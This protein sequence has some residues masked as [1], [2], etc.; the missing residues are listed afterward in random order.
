MFEDLTEEQIAE[1]VTKVDK[2]YGAGIT[3][4][5][6]GTGCHLGG[7]GDIAIEYDESDVVLVIAACEGFRFL[8]TLFKVVHDAGS[9]MSIPDPFDTGEGGVI[10][11]IKV[12]EDSVGSFSDGEVTLNDLTQYI[13]SGIGLAPN[14]G[15]IINHVYEHGQGMAVEFVH[16]VIHA[17][18]HLV[19]E[20]EGIDYSKLESFDIKPERQTARWN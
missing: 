17:G 13:Q 7:F 6:T 16:A 1:I 3:G 8:A 15:E 20:T 18:A 4:M 9:L 10:T 19:H 11:A 5:I 14:V 12:D 2:Q